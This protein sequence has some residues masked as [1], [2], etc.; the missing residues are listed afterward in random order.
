M[1]TKIT[2]KREKLDKLIDN[3][4][5]LAAKKVVVGVLGAAGSDLVNIAVYNEFG[6]RT[7]PERSFI[8]ATFASRQAAY[9]KAMSRAVKAVLS[10]RITPDQ[11]RGLLAVQAVA[12]VQKRIVDIRTPPNAK[13]TIARKGSSNPLIDTGRLR[14]SIQSDTRDND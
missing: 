8:R 2:V 10:R 5:A 7:I 13:E 4:K 3:L 9:I 1:K 6:T 12:D 11:A 14:Q